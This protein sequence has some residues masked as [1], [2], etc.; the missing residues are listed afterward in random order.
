MVAYL[1]KNGKTKAAFDLFEQALN[2]DF[3]AH[4]KL[5]DYQHNLEQNTTLLQIIRSFDKKE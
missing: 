5:F 4:K 3:E 1:L 2:I